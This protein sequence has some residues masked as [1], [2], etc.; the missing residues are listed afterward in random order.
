MFILSCCVINMKKDHTVYVGNRQVLR[1]GVQNFETEGGKLSPPLTF[2]VPHIS[3]KCDLRVK[4]YY[5]STGM[6]LVDKENIHKIENSLDK[7]GKWRKVGWDGWSILFWSPLRVAI[8]IERHWVRVAY[9]MPSSLE[10]PKEVVLIATK[11]TSAGSL[12]LYPLSLGEWG[13]VW[14]RLLFSHR[15]RKNINRRIYKCVQVF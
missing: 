2:L 1:K 9:F 14:L 11:V 4:M 15:D 7:R 13:G 6:G 3:T 5:K 12:R 8:S 10:T